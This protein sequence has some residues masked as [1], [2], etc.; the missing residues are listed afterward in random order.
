LGCNEEGQLV[1]IAT[2]TIFQQKTSIGN[3]EQVS[4]GAWRQ[5]KHSK[6]KDIPLYYMITVIVIVGDA[7]PKHASLWLFGRC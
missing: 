7:P 5:Q 3:V 2:N 4:R 1:D 6:M